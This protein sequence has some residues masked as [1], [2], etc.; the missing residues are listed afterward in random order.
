MR[1]E[2]LM[3]GPE[4]PGIYNVLVKDL[5]WITFQ[6]IAHHSDREMKAAGAGSS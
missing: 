5:F 3:Q 1:Q 2:V 4:H 6:D